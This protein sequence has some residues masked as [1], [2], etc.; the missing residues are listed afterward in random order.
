MNGHTNVRT[1]EKIVRCILACRV[2][3]KETLFAPAI[4]IV[5]SMSDGVVYVIWPYPFPEKQRNQC[6]FVCTRETRNWEGDLREYTSNTCKKR[7]EPQN[8]EHFL[9]KRE[10]T[11]KG[12]WEW[13]WT[14]WYIGSSPQFL[15]LLS[16][17]T[18]RQIKGLL[19]GSSLIWVRLC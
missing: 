2:D 18:S 17:I 12:E 1:D 11:G 13:E 16:R 14:V 4:V 3:C 7:D 10:I 9:V 8:L 6:A 5:E 19:G 15:A